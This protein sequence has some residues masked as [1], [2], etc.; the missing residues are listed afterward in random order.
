MRIK[1]LAKVILNISERYLPE[2]I[3][4]FIEAISRSTNCASSGASPRMI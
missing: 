3:T 1:F 4:D 2:E